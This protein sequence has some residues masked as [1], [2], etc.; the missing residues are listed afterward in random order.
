MTD[1]SGLVLQLLGRRLSKD[2]S[3]KARLGQT[4]T[5]HVSPQKIKERTHRITDDDSIEIEV[6]THIE[7]VTPDASY[8]WSIPH[9]GMYRCFH[10]VRKYNH[11]GLLVSEELVKG[12]TM[13]G[14]KRVNR[15]YDPPG[16]LFPVRKI[17][18]SVGP[19]CYFHDFG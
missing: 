16:S 10:R 14:Q 2:E 5:I 6:N 7:T 12:V 1:I 15:E 11:E 18:T 4:E 19:K 8:G 3:D 9:T 13:C 17:D